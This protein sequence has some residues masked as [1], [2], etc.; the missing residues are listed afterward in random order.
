MKISVCTYALH[1]VY[2]VYPRCIN[3]DENLHIA[4]SNPRCKTPNGSLN[5]S[6]K[7]GRAV[8]RQIPAELEIFSDQFLGIRI[9]ATI[10]T[11]YSLILFEKMCL[12]CSF[13]TYQSQSKSQSKQEAR[14]SMMMRQ[15]STAVSSKE[16]QCVCLRVIG[17]KFDSSL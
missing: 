10:M 15:E 14:R 13:P 12:W 7:E 9:C 3:C 5:L 17:S 6:L 1:V 2:Y 16:S 11:G 8:G 4:I